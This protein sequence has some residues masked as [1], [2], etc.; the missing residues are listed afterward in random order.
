M[1]L[2]LITCRLRPGKGVSAAGVVG[3]AGMWSGS[4]LGVASV[5]G[6]K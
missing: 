6:L 4:G 3:C 5:T 2:A 1:F